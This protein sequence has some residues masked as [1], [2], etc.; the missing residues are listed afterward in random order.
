[1]SKL[2]IDV[3]CDVANEELVETPV[4]ANSKGKL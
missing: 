1:M 2:F 3:S 4:F